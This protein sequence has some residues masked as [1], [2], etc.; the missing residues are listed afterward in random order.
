M[1]DRAEPRQG[2]L[3]E[4]SVARRFGK[5]LACFAL[6]PALILLAATVQGQMHPGSA[7]KAGHHGTAMTSSAK[8]EYPTMAG[9]GKKVAIGGDRFLIYSFDKKPKLGTLIMKVQIVDAKGVKDTSFDVKADAGMPSMKGAHETG[10][11]PFALSK[12]GDY[13]LPINIVMPGDWEVRLT[14]LKEGKALF[15]GSYQFDV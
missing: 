5:L 10:E 12:K 9:P 13:L 2:T 15:R 7:T 4:T 14:I 11:R 6:V 1:T 3:N 8:A